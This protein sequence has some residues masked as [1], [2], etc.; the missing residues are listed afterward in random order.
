MAGN[1]I[2]VRGCVHTNGV[3]STGAIL[4]RTIN[5]TYHKM[6]PK[7]LDRYVWGFV[8]KHNCRGMGVLGRMRHVVAGL[9]GWMPT[10]AELVAPNGLPVGARS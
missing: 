1:G 3:E 2:G 9:R 6:S 7:H 10:R 4:K 8:R 5:G